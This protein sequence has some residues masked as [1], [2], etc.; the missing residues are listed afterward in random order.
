MDGNRFDELG[1]VL[2]GQDSRRGVFRLLSGAVIGAVLGIPAADAPAKPKK[3]CPKK[4][5]PAGFL[6][7][8]STCKCECKRTPCRGGLEF[9]LK[10]CRCKCPAGMRECKDHCVAKDECCPGDPPCPEDPKGCCHAPGLDVCTIDGCCRELDGMKACNNF[11]IDTNTSNFHCG[12]CNLPCGASERCVGGEC[13][14]VGE[15]PNGGKVCQGPSGPF[16]TP[17]DTFSC[18]GDN[19]CNAF[20]E[21]CDASQDLCCLKGECAQADGICCTNGR[22]LCGGKCCPFGQKCCGG[23]C[24]S[25]MSCLDNRCCRTAVCGGANAAHKVCRAEGEFCCTPS[26]DADGWACPRGEEAPGSC[27]TN[28]RC[29]P[30]GTFYED[31]CGKCCRDVRD[32][33]S[34]C[35]APT[36]GRTA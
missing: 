26:S 9:D 35:I 21:C 15:C 5:C 29:C 25:A 6:R 17:N 4:P 12:G 28:G 33:C 34:E 13:Q 18:C 2:G 20:R 16:C 27:A 22:D 30:P 7:N 24:C 36:P 3:K 1:R 19:A 14:P 8:K 11:C 10:S 31:G 23:E 32:L